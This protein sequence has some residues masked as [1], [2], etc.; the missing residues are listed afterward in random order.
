MYELPKEKKKKQEKKKENTHDIIKVELTSN[1]LN[2][3]QI[4]VKI[5]SP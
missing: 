1:F 4:K 2:Y 5:E 3:R